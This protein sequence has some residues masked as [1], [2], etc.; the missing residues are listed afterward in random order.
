MR[1]DK[2]QVG[3]VGAGWMGATQ[4]KR[5]CERDDVTIVALAD[6]NEAGAKAVLAEL[7][8]PED[9]YV[10]DYEAIVQNPDIAA[11]WLVSPNCYHGPQAI[12]ALEA[13]K[14]VFCEKPAAT[15]YADFVREIDLERAHP[16]LHTFVDYILYFDAME[17]RLRDMVAAD[18]FGQI[19][20]IQVNYRHPVNI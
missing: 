19:T 10:K 13:G 5:L 6:P 12:A 20:Q 14:H 3:F 16:H 8:L 7:G 17:Q 1:N 4:M 2:L 9:V 15:T 11:V 18:E